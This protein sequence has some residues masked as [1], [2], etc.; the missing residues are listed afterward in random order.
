MPKINVY[1]GMDG[2]LRLHR[3]AETAYAEMI[4]L[5]KVSPAV[6]VRT[7]IPLIVNLTVPMAASAKKTSYG[8]G[9]HALAFVI[10]QSTA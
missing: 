9:K 5:L 4:F 1:V 2:S 7:V 6:F 3:T 10:Q 8:A